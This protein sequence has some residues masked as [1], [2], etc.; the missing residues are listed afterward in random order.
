MANFLKSNNIFISKAVSEGCKN[1][2]E[3]N[4]RYAD[5]LIT[6]D[7]WCF[8]KFMIQVISYSINTITEIKMSF[9]YKE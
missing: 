9:N 3:V 7:R 5:A 1:M 4:F 2:Y 6:A 8:V